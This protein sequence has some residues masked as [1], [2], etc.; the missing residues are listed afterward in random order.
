MKNFEY[1]MFNKIYNASKIEYN[2][3]CSAEATKILK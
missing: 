3:K 2:S 1:F